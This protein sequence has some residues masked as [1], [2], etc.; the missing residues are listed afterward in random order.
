MHPLKKTFWYTYIGVVQ[1]AS[2][3]LE[4]ITFTISYICGIMEDVGNTHARVHAHT[5]VV[6]LP[7]LIE[8]SVF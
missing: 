5:L 7:T 1:A 4:L 3:S 2:I 8:M 6:G